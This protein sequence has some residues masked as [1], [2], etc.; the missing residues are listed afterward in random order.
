[1]RVLPYTADAPLPVMGPFDLLTLSMGADEVMYRESH[2][3]DEVVEEPLTV[4]RHHRMFETW[5]EAALGEVESAKLIA[6]CADELLGSSSAQPPPSSE[7]DASAEE[8]STPKAA[9]RR[10]RRT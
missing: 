9:S 1:L 10:R 5:W 2:L 4:G 6:K 7:T 3:I 8:L